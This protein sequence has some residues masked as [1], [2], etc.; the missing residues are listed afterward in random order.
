M[1][2]TKIEI[3][4]DEKSIR[5]DKANNLFQNKVLVNVAQVSQMIPWVHI[6]YLK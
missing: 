1:A 2:Y 4:L 5:R 3:H 6:S